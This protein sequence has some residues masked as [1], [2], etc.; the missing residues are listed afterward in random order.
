V[1]IETFIVV[2]HSDIHA[3]D[4]G[5]AI[6]PLV[7]GTRNCWIIAVGSEVTKLKV[8]ELAGVGCFVDSAE[9]VLVVWH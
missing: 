4:W 7:P 9:L 6:Y 3:K 8:G 5:P 1:Q 2:C